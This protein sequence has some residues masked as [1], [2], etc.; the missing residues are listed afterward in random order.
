M[1]KDH[2]TFWNYTLSQEECLNLLNRAYISPAALQKNYCEN[3]I[4]IIFYQSSL[5]NPSLLTCRGVTCKTIVSILSCH[6]YKKSYHFNCKL[7]EYIR[8]PNVALIYFWSTNGLF[9]TPSMHNNNVPILFKIHFMNQNVTCGRICEVI[10]F[11][12]VPRMSNWIIHYS[13]YIY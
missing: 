11:L 2:T 5:G 7:K 10:Q 1:I 8:S 9:N 4:K 13:N 6:L 3:E 12:Q